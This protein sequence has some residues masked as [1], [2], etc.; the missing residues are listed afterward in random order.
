MITLL[1]F[2]CSQFNVPV[3][4][5]RVK[6]RYCLWNCWTF[7]RLET[8]E[9]PHDKTNKMACA[10]WRLR[11]AWAFAQS[12]QSSLTAWRKLGSLAIHWV[13]SKDSDQTGRMP[14]LIYLH[15]LHSHFVGF[16]M[17]WIKCQTQALVLSFRQL[18]HKG[19]RQ[20]TGPG[21]SVGCTSAWHANGRLHI[22][23]VGQISFVEIGYEIISRA[24]LFLLLIQVAQLSVTGERMC[25]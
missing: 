23:L 24:I 5:I 20:L 3:N 8:N 7:T 21:S 19:T 16:V 25:I 11:S 4:A 15:W 22:P 18:C 9:P 2:D 10:Q 13:R 6:S 17:R 12:N 14:R 1:Q